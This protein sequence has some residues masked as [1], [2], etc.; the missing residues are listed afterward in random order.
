MATNA[1]VPVPD[2]PDSEPV[3]QLVDLTKDF[4]RQRAVNSVTMTIGK[5]EI[6]GLLGPNGAGKS[7]IIRMLLG[8]VRPTSGEAILWG[9]DV[10][11][12]PGQ[13]ARV[14]SLV[15]GG[16][17]YPFLTARQNLDVLGRMTGHRDPARADALLE[18]VGLADAMDKRVKGFSTGMRQ[19]LGVA[20][21]L[22]GD[23]EFVILDEP[24]NGLDVRGISDM[25]ELILRLARDQGRTVLLCS[26][27][28]AEVEQVCTRIGILDKGR[29][30]HEA[31]MADMIGSPDKVR[32]EAAPLEAA[33]SVLAGRWGVQAEKGA[34]I[35]AA[36]RDEAPAIAAALIEVKVELF[37]LSMER[38]SLETVYNSIVEGAGA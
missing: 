12:H 22:L 21:A 26:H 35:V 13:L 28:L 29:I 7:T 4:G 33:Q 1:D 16:T 30:I 38:R 9:Q 34:L 2:A 5:G 15:D 32:V 25:R 23:P 6:Y 11:T 8:L 3:V 37:H 27:V 18:Q 10:R 20:A 14:G 17:L 31:S 19:R 36:T 24:A